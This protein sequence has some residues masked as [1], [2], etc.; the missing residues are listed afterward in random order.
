MA[1]QSGGPG[2]L[3]PDAKAAAASTGGL[4]ALNGGFFTPDGD[5]LGLV[6]AGGKRAGSLNR[7]SSLGAGLYIDSGSPALIRRDKGSAAPTILQSGPFL[8]E[9]GRRITG[10]SPDSSSARSIIGWDGGSGWFIARSGTCSLAELG[11]V[12]AGGQI[13]GVTAHTVLN[14][15]GGRSS[16][17]WASPALPGGPVNQRPFWNKPVRNFL[18]LLPRP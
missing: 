10:L 5:P 4:A 14:L 9:N 1:D 7:A 12:L 15:D 16:D 17:L 13:G 2:S 11:S 8:V 18:V 6:V 3:W